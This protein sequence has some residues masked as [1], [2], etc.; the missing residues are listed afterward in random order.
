[1]QGLTTTVYGT[2]QNSATTTLQGP[3]NEWTCKRWFNNIATNVSAK[4]HRYVGWLVA[5]FTAPVT[6]I[7][8]LACDLYHGAKSLYQ[9][10]VHKIESPIELQV[11]STGREQPVI[12]GEPI[13]ARSN[14]PEPTMRSEFGVIPPE[15]KF[16]ISHMRDA[17]PNLNTH[18][19]KLEAELDNAK[20]KLADTERDNAR[21]MAEVRQLMTQIEAEAKQFADQLRAKNNKLNAM[22]QEYS[23]LK[24]EYSAMKQEYIARIH[25]LNVDIEAVEMDRDDLYEQLN[26]EYKKNAIQAD[27]INMLRSLIRDQNTNTNT[28]LAS[29]SDPNTTSQQVFFAAFNTTGKDDEHSIITIGSDD[30]SPQLSEYSNTSGDEGFELISQFLEGDKSATVDVTFNDKDDQLTATEENN[31]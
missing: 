16:S 28:Q 14:S 27:E 11:S 2:E 10:N 22:K 15:D 18:L 21:V 29:P 25:S 6:F 3:S 1:M 20:Q 17:F 13:I 4:T 5:A 26:E 9:R 19:A 23:V 24:Q 12:S 8:S 7:P 31:G 30:S